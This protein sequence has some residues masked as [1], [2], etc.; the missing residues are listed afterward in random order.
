MITVPY[1]ISQY[2][3]ED[4]CSCLCVYMCV[5]ICSQ[6]CPTLCDPVDCSPPGSS[7]HGIFQAR[8]LEWVAISYSRGSSQ[9]RDWISISWVS[10]IGR[11]MLYHC[12]TWEVLVVKNPPANTR[13]MYPW[14]FPLKTLAHWLSGVGASWP[15]GKSPPFPYT[16]PLLPAF[17]INQTFLSTK[18][19]S[20]LA[21][22]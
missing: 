14:N 17:K 4:Y 6:L 10:C 22:E 21:L 2:F 3:L 18:L 5:C 11:Q 12:A 16:P 8:K 19:A 13:D 7:V 20:L 9:S 1:R 15:L